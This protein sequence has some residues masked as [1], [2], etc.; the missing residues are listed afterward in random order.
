MSA[1]FTALFFAV[2]AA[3]FIYV[4]VARA[5]GNANPNQSYI[6]AGA[7]GLVIFFVIFTLLK[8]VLGF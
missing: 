4:K 3:G 2:G 8:F 5:T 6:V 1:F 7:A